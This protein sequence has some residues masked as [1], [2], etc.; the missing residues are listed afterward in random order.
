MNQENH[1]NKALAYIIAGI[2]V[3]VFLGAYIYYMLENAQPVA[4][5]P[6]NSNGTI[7]TGQ[8]MLS[9][10]Q[11]AAKEAI[12]ANINSQKPVQLTPAQA[13]AKAAALKQLQ[14]GSK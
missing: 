6:I 1:T 12:I 7:S 4:N 2:V 3:I 11:A 9:P 14:A 10:E 13:A 8:V 5:Q